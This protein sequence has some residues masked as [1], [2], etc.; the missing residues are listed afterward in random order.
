VG[1]NSERGHKQKPCRAGKPAGLSTRLQGRL[2]KHVPWFEM[3]LVHTAEMT[4][5]LH[6]ESPQRHTNGRA[7]ELSTQAR[8]LFRRLG[9]ADTKRGLQLRQCRC[10]CGISA[11]HKLAPALFLDLLLLSRID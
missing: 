5:E 6:S 2:A 11:R 4:G 9:D 8:P 3:G 1:L 7:A 10:G